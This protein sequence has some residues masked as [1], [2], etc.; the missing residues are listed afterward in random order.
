MKP[1]REKGPKFFHIPG[2][3][4]GVGGDEIVGQKL[5]LAGLFREAVEK[6]GEGKEEVGPRFS[7]Q[8]QDRGLRVFRRDLHL[9]RDVVPDDLPQVFLS[10]PFIRQH[11]VVSDP[12][13]DDDLFD[14]GDLPQGPEEFDL[15]GVVDVQFG[16][17]FRKEALPVPAGPGRGLT[18]AFD[19]VHIGCGASHVVEGPL[20]F[21]MAGD[22]SCLGED[23][24]LAAPADPASFVD[25]DGAEA[26]L[27][28]TSPVSGDG[29]PNRLEGP[30]GSLYP[31]MG[32]KLSFVIQVVNGIQFFL[33][34]VGCRGI[35]D[36][37][38]SVLPL[39]EGEGR[40]RIVVPVE[41]FEH[42]FKGLFVL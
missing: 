26:A 22:F 4:A 25:G 9:S 28:V 41:G 36:Q 10:V 23:G 34:E 1:F 8:V 29:E 2:R 17:Y 3:A 6:A 13:G 20:E 5:F 37:K 39:R 12:G 18:G 40:N 33:G 30:D 38:P 31:I 19:P 24:S 16:T 14:A 7:H 11:H 42:L 35:L 15:R 27:A 21:R 32:V